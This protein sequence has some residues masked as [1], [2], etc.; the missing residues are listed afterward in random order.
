[1]IDAGE[2]ANTAPVPTAS[3]TPAVAPT[4][5]VTVPWR[6]DT[7]AVTTD[8]RF[9]VSCTVAWPLT[10]VVAEPA[11]SVPWVLE[12]VT[13][14]LANGRLPVAT[15][16]AVTVTVPPLA[17]T[18]AGAARTETPVTAAAPTVIVT[19]LV[20]PV[21]GFAAAPDSARIVATPDPVPALKVA[22]ATPLVVVVSVGAIEPMSVTNRTVVP[23]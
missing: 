13:G 23:F 18:L 17:G 19:A 2:P 9:V 22:V 4:V 12:K 20:P 3:V 1:V 6:P 5:T 8:S 16:L 11:L 15:T 21:C 10:S 14:T 7:A